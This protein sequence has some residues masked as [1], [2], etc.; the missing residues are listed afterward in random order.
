MTG[1]GFTI[2][3]ILPQGQ[4]NGKQYRGGASNAKKIS[5]P[6]HP[7]GGYHARI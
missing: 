7:L 6:F 1:L 3:I 4:L 5:V 2:A